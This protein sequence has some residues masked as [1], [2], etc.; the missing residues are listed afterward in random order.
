MAKS[1]LAERNKAI[2]EAWSKEQELVQE[3]KGTREWMP[4]QQKDILEKGRAY[5]DKGKHSKDSI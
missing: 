3:G 2:R 5:D 1:S 4:E